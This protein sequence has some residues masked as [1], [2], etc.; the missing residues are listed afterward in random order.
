MWV[1][2]FNFVLLFINYFI[3]FHMKNYKSS[4]APPY[5]CVSN[6]AHFVLGILK[7]IYMTSKL[8]T[9]FQLFLHAMLCFWNVSMLTQVDKVLWVFSNDLKNV[10]YTGI[11]N[12]SIF[13]CLNHAVF[14]CFREFFSPNILGMYLLIKGPK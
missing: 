12:I 9:N 10:S 5:I 14:W 1:H 6:N 11:H 13:K 7:C 3:I 4:F 8:E 2:K